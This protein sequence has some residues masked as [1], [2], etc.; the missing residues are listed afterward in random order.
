MTLGGF[1]QFWGVVFIAATLGI[2]LLKREAPPPTGGG[3][4]VDEL[5]DIRDAYRRMPVG[6][7][8]AAR[9]QLTCCV[10]NQSEARRKSILNARPTEKCEVLP[11]DSLSESDTF[12][13]F[14]MQACGS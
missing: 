4:D 7:K 6:A 1:M 11:E 14:H 3:E 8:G 13:P 9:R 2:A 12:W 5:V 10:L